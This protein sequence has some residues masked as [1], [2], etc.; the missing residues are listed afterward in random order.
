MAQAVSKLDTAK[1]DKL[2][3]EAEDITEGLRRFAEGALEGRYPAAAGVRAL[4]VLAKLTGLFTE[5]PDELQDRSVVFTYPVGHEP[6]SAYSLQ[7]DRNL[8]GS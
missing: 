3:V 2:G 8:F 6:D 7:L 4:E 5:R 1:R